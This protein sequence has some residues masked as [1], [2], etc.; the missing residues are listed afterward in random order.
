MES[1]MKNGGVEMECGKEYD[2]EFES[3]IHYIQ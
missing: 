1:V 2:T 3:G